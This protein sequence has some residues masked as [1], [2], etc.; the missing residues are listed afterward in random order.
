LYSKGIFKQDKRRLKR[1]CIIMEIR[2]TDC[3][4]VSLNESVLLILNNKNL[5]KELD[6]VQQM[7]IDSAE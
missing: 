5:E 2:S 3:E 6:D 1:A 4:N 7:I